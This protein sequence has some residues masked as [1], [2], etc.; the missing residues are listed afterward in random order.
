MNHR[1]SKLEVGAPLLSLIA[2]IVVGL[3]GASG[4]AAAAS[5]CDAGKW[6][7]SAIQARF[8]GALPAL[9]SG[10]ALPGLGAP[11][12]INLA[13]QGEVTFAHAPG[14]AGKAKPAYAAVVKLGAEPAATYQVTVS[15]GAW[16]DM[17]ENG[18]L[19]K[20]SG[21]VRGKDCPG[22]DKSIRFKTDGGPLTLQISG[23]YAKTIKLEAARAE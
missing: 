16:V 15:E 13:A 9:A 6:P 8:A 12:L 23:A 3:F 20:Q 19:V 10:D 5:G 7:L 1:R 11:V 17:V 2:P 21:Y 22:V 14:R 18:E 4:A